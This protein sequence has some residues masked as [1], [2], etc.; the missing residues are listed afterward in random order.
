[1]P[2]AAP[3]RTGLSTDPFIEH[4]LELLAPA[5]AGA[6]LKARRMFGGWG[7]SWDGLS[8]A[9]V[10][11]GRFYLKTDAQT[12]THFR[13]A[14]CQPFTYEAKGKRMEMSYWTP[15]DETMDAA[16]LMTPWARKA[17]EAALRAANAKAAVKPVAKKAGVRKA[18]KKTVAKTAPTKKHGAT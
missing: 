2:P 3:A 5:A 16:H 17:I 4:L 9:I 7:I 10:A 18:A 14:G 15:P 8:I 6:P 1:M 13:E 11:D 12:Q